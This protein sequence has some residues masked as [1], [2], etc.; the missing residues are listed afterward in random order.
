MR[1]QAAAILAVAALTGTVGGTDARHGTE[2]APARRKGTPMRFA[3]SV[4][5][6]ATTVVSPP[7]LAQRSSAVRATTAPVAVPAPPGPHTL[8]VEVRDENGELL[9][10]QAPFARFPGVGRP[11]RTPRFRWP[12]EAI[13]LGP[14]RWSFRTLPYTTYT[15][16]R[17]SET[18]SLVEQKIKTGA[19][20]QE[21]TTT[22]FAGAE[23]E[24]SRLT[25]EVR[26]AT[27]I[28]GSVHV[29]V[30]SPLSDEAL[31]VES[32]TLVDGR[33]KA[34]FTLPSGW[35]TVRA[36]P[37]TAWLFAAEGKLD[38]H[39]GTDREHILFSNLGGQVRFLLDPPPGKRLTGSLR[40]SDGRRVPLSYAT[41]TGGGAGF[42]P[43]LPLEPGL[44]EVTVSVLGYEPVTTK[45]DVRAG[46][47]RD[48][49][50]VLRS[51]ARPGSPHGPPR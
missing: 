50:I 39:A 41:V 4:L 42:T 31:L 24:P 5:L 8:I 2:R 20:R 38:L 18:R 36:T 1:I 30:R 48:V 23:Q 6:V 17:F 22:L 49:S 44:Q 43:L 11:G 13:R 12:T 33:L 40:T 34:E 28:S 35:Y 37:Q 47:R 10:D 14:G 16:G 26:A 19:S 15:V 25:V 45:V 46:V 9:D 32:G 29:S 7:A 51:V 21:T 3:L 27:D